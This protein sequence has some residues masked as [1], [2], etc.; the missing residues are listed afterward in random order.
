MFTHVKDV[1]QLPELE[2][3]T[4][5]EGR[6][7]VLP[8]G[9][10]VPSVTTVLGAQSKEGIEKWKEKVGEEEA[11]KV[12]HQAGVR[13]TEVHEL[14]E[15]FINNKPDW[16]AGYQPANLFTFNQIR[17]ILEN[18]LDNVW[19]QECPLYSMR[20]RTA[21]RLDC[22]A[23]W[24]GELSI[25]DFKTSRKPKKKEWIENYFLQASFYAAAFYELTGVAI[26]KAVIVMAVDGDDPQIF[27]E[28]V[29]KWLPKFIQVRNAYD[30]SITSDNT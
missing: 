6:R 25:I 4:T 29:Y 21:G 18:N 13:G 26:K 15:N 12:L 22:M 16:S 14:A 19:Y 2:A 27:E 10:M 9:E 7:Y 30:G 28:D 3:I 20:L 8:N 5:A 23:E 24:N 17:Y 11:A 1:P